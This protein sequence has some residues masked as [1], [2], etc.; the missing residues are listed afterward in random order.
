MLSNIAKEINFVLLKN[1]KLSDSKYKI[2]AKSPNLSVAK[3]ADP[4][5]VK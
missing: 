1:A 5:I 4:Q 3:Y 2:F